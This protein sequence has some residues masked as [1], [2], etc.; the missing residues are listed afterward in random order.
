MKDMKEMSAI[1]LLNLLKTIQKSVDEN[2][3][4]LPGDSYISYVIE[5]DIE[6]EYVVGFDNWKSLFPTTVLTTNNVN[7]AMI[8]PTKE[9]TESILKEFKTFKLKKVS[10]ITVLITQE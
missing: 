6:K 8:F 10:R 2:I 5:T 1:E 3:R 4:S 9:S 7:E